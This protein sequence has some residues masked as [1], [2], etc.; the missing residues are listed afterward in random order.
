MGKKNQPQKVEVT[1]QGHMARP[2]QNHLEVKHAFITLPIGYESLAHLRRI[3]G[4][5]V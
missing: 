3:L 5:G 4:S 1:S 2:W